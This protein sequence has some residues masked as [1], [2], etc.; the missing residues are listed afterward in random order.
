MARATQI[1]HDAGVFQL[2]LPFQLD[3]P[4]ESGGPAG[5]VARSS[6][7]P[8]RAPRVKRAR[9]QRAGS[10]SLELPS[11]GRGALAVEQLPE[12]EARG[13]TCEQRNDA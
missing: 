7:G 2:I 5:I 4:F 13:T 11:F 12:G 1:R 10:T 8:V 9:R 3:L 6:G